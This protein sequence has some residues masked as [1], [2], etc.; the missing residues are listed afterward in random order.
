MKTAII[1][2]DRFID[3][4]TGPSHPECPGRLEAIISRLR[5]SGTWDRL[6]RPDFEPADMAWIE[7]V[8]STAYINRLR[9][10]CEQ[11]R[12]FIDVPDSAICPGSFDVA[13]LAVGG[14]LAAVDAV[15][16]GQVDNALCALRP[17][18]H[19]AEHDRSMG[20][21]MFNNIAIAAEYLLEKHGLKR[22]AI[23]D[24]DVHHGNGTQ[25]TFESRDDVL[26]ISLH[27]D[28]QFMY[29]GTGY[30]H[31]EGMGRG[32]GLTVNVPLM[33]RSTDYDYRQ[34]FQKQVIPA[35]DSFKPQFLLVSA[36][37]D[38]HELDPIG[39]QRVTDEGFAWMAA[40]LRAAADRL[41][42]GRLL[43]AL[44]GGYHFEAQAKCVE[45]LLEVLLA[46]PEAS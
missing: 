2:N 13:R 42:G 15:M 23:V 41:C 34:A 4:D 7:R 1:Y 43:V 40:E 28:P 19:H 6:V 12:M 29:P 37:Y 10:A 16:A 36:G 21:C 9:S 32:Q 30:A 22:V 35:V 20:F 14:I 39:H 27:E 17:P 3:H 8:H 26:F 5:D 11:G 18:G 46:P 25:H 31:E 24:F 44:E 38:P 45:Q 33:P